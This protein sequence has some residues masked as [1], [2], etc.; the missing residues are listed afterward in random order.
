M[1]IPWFAQRSKIDQIKPNHAHRQTSS[2]GSITPEIHHPIWR[3]NRWP[4]LGEH[5]E[6]RWS[7]F[8]R[9]VHRQTPS[10]ETASRDPALPPPNVMRQQMA[11]P[12][13]TC[14]AKVIKFHPARPPSNPIHQRATSAFWFCTRFTHLTIETS[15]LVLES[16]CAPRTQPGNLARLKSVTFCLNRVINPQRTNSD[17]YEIGLINRSTRGSWAYPSKHKR[18]SLQPQWANI[19]R[20]HTLAMSISLLNGWPRTNL[21][22]VS[23]YQHRV[24]R[25]SD[26]LATTQTTKVIL[27]FFRYKSFLI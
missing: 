2:I 16:L 8:T 17:R 9:Q 20:A 4:Y 27:F 22:Q 25:P 3:V 21:N 24:P 26:G 6:Q 1:T 14:R 7:N 13:C 23:N 19:V 10:I 15:I 18:P 5:A 11:I 12:W